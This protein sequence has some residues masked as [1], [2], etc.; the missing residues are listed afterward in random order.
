LTE[1]RLFLSIICEKCDLNRAIKNSFLAPAIVA[2]AI[3]DGKA[4]TKPQ[5]LSKSHVRIA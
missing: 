1:I 4:L 3:F 5:Q 2:L